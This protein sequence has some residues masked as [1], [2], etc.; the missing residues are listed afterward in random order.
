MW[1]CRRSRRRK[2]R[3]SWDFCETL[4]LFDWD[5][6]CKLTLAPETSLPTF[7]FACLKLLL[8]LVVRV[9][10]W[11]RNIEVIVTLGIMSHPT[12][13]ALCLKWGFDLAEFMM[14]Q[15][16]AVTAPVTW[17]HYRERAEL[18]GDKAAGW[19]SPAGGVFCTCSSSNLNRSLQKTSKQSL[20]YWAKHI[21]MW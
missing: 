7:L 12:V 13:I 6:G 20:L 15:I 2:T 21:C 16:W 8:F 10:H 9:F 19:G 18:D 4:D 11:N 14:S 3:C 5:Q 1:S 17:A